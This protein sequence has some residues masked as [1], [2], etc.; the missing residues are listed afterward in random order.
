M[1]CTFIGG[2]PQC[3]QLNR[4]FTR[5]EKHCDFEQRM[6]KAAQLADHSLILCRGSA[7]VIQGFDEVF[8]EK[9]ERD[10]IADGAECDWHPSRE[11]FE[12]DLNL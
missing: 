10:D 12:V 4:L 5:S 1:L 3:I 2:N 6:V 8:D 9:A 7:A 11:V